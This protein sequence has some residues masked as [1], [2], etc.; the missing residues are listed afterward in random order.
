MKTLLRTLACGG[1]ALSALIAGAAEYPSRPVRF[2]VPYATGG[3]TDI[4]ARIIGPK[5]TQAWRQQIVVDNR[6][7][8][9][10]NIG[11]DIVAKA[12]PDG[13]TILLG[14]SG[15]NAVNPSVY[16]RMP[17][18]A[19][20][21]LALIAMVASTANILVANPRFAGN[22]IQDVLAMAKKN[23]GKVT[24]GSAGVGSVLH[25]SGELLKTM[26]G[27]NMTHVPYKGTGPSLVDL[28]G[29]QIDVVFANLPAVVPM[30]QTGRLKGIAVTTAKRATAL[31]QIPTMMEG[32][33]RGYDVSSW[34]AVFVPTRTPKPIVSKINAE[35]VKI[36]KTPDTQARL[37][38]LGAEPMFMTPAEG[39]R[40]FHDE[41]EKWAKVVKAAGVKPN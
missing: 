28:M 33:V 14:T 6:G 26:T 21:D 1:L 5:L 39:N 38:E 17:Y 18:D 19:K 32:G 9:N 41:I 20:R 11:S 2:V 8:A 15:S 12:T 4:L 40:F 29:G 25:L 37:V 23:P 27:V 30:V 31:P 22:T 24:Y 34:F 36:L 10:G 13:Y 35:V 7:G 3:T 16:A